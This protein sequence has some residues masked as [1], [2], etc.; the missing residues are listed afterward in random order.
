MAR[1]YPTVCAETG[2]AEGWPCAECG[3]AEVAEAGWIC[4]HCD[5]AGRASEAAA[6]AAWVAAEE[7]RQADEPCELCGRFACICDDFRAE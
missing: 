1:T 4:D 5:D 3:R 7:A 6:G 2:Y